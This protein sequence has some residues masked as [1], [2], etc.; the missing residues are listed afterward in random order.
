SLTPSHL[1]TAASWPW[2]GCGR[3]G[4]L[5]PRRRYGFTIITTTSNETCAEVHN[6][7]PVI[8]PPEARSEW[9]SEEPAEEAT[10]KRMLASYRADR[11]TVWPV[12][13]RVGSVKNNDPSL[14]E[15]ISTRRAAR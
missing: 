3:R 12:D 13:K 11:M 8:L 4:V 6:R 5:R 2:Q 10:L 9:L 14:I 15:P 7:M 1:L